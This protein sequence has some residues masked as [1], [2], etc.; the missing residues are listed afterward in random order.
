MSFSPRTVLVPL[1]GASQAGE[2]VARIEATAGETAQRPDGLEPAIASLIN[3]S[4]YPAGAA[5]LGAV[6]RLG[7]KR[8]KALLAEW[9]LQG[10]PATALTVTN[11]QDLTGLGADNTSSAELGLALAYLMHAAQSRDRLVIATGALSRNTDPL[12]ATRN[13]EILPVGGIAEKIL[14][15]KRSLKTNK[16]AAWGQRVLFFLPVNSPDDRHTADAYVTELRELRDDFR[17]VGLALEV[18]PVATLEQAADRL[19]IDRLATT[20]AEQW[21]NR[22]ALGCLGLVVA[23]VLVYRWINAPIPL[24]FAPLPLSNAENAMSPVRVRY[25][26]GADGH[27]MLPPCLGAQRMPVVRIG[28]SLA[29]RVVVT[30]PSRVV[31]ALG[32][33]RFL[34]VAVSENS[35]AKVFPPE[36]IRAAPP[37]A[38][39]AV[40]TRPH[41]GTLQYQ[42]SAV[43]P[44]VPPAETSKLFVLAKRIVPFD[45]DA[46]RVS[47][48]AVTRPHPPHQRINAAVT[49]L[50]RLAPG[51][52]DY[53][54]K[55]ADGDVE[56]KPA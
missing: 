7:L 41:V 34:L 4:L 1:A 47:L 35:G 39:Q 24:G 36:A 32:G 42:I 6:R 11:G 52:L 19:G 18:C 33:Y 8:R 15:L 20:A 45:A 51:Y 38:K 44:V 23:G 56:C 14:A 37:A 30:E 53:S 31:D 2:G 46:V 12:T 10:P 3:W 50:A 22:I 17:A 40:D 54:F 43:V 55:S 13:V 5:A 27:T 21:L 49:F 26:L 25:E 9:I 16:G 28:E 48:E 29:L